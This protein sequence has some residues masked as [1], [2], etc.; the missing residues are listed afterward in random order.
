MRK[1]ALMLV[2][3]LT[4]SLAVACNKARSDAALV[5]VQPGSAEKV[6]GISA[7]NESADLRA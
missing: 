5:M 7:V 6:A 1:T 4:L 3:V 2:V